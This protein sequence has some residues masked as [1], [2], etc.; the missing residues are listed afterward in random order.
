[1]TT[2][3][4]IEKWCWILIFVGMI[5]LALGLSVQR[6]DVTLGWCIT[7]PGVLMVA[8]GIALIWVRSRM[9]DSKE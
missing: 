8:V 4:R 9:K 1:M 6:S 2:V 7:A 5:L 3:Q